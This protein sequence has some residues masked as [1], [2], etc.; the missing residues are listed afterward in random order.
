M[1]SSSAGN[2]NPTTTSEATATEISDAANDIMDGVEEVGVEEVGAEHQ[3]DNMDAEENDDSVE[4]PDIESDDEILVDMEDATD[5]RFLA[6]GYKRGHFSLTHAASTSVTFARIEAKS[7]KIQVTLKKSGQNKRCGDKRNCFP[8][9][10][11][12]WEGASW[13]NPEREGKG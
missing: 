7:R 4:A 2:Q 8:R 5:S 11:R 10:E 9:W 6:I 13:R 3:N 1:A 12:A